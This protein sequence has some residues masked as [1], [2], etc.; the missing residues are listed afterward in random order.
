[1]RR[2]H[3]G[4]TPPLHHP[5]PPGDFKTPTACASTRPVRT[6][7]AGVSYAPI[8][9]LRTQY[10]AAAR[11]HLATKG[12]GI[13]AACEARGL[14]KTGS[15]YHGTYYWVQKYKQNGTAK[16]IQGSDKIAER[17]TA[18][19]AAVPG[20]AP[21]VVIPGSAPRVYDDIDTDEDFESYG[22]AYMK[23][24]VLMSG[25]QAKTYAKA[26]LMVQ[27]QMGWEIKKCSA[28]KS[29]K[30]F[31]L[32]V[33][34][35]PGRKP[36]MGVAAE[37][38]MVRAVHLL[39]S[40]RLPAR[41]HVVLRMATNM[42]LTV[43]LDLDLDSITGLVK[44]SWFYSFKDRHADLFDFSATKGL[45]DTR[46]DWLTSRNA[47]IHYG[48]LAEQLMQSKI[49]KRA[50]DAAAQAAAVNGE[51]IDFLSEDDKA[52]LVSF[53]ECRTTLDTY[54]DEARGKQLNPK[55]M[56]DDTLETR[57]FGNVTVV[58]GSRGDGKALP[59]MAIFPRKTM[60]KVGD[61][62]S[63]WTLDFWRQWRRVAPASPIC[64]KDG[65]PLMAK[66]MGNKSGGM[67]HD[68]GAIY[69]R[70]VIAPAMPELTKEKPGILVCDGHGSHLT[71]EFL[72]TAIALNIIVILRPPHTTSRM[73]GEDTKHGFGIFQAA[74]RAAKEDILCTRVVAGESVTV[75]DFMSAMRIA[76]DKAFTRENCRASWA[77]IGVVPF[78]RCVFWELAA[79]EKEIARCKAR[80]EKAEDVDEVLRE[81]DTSTLLTASKLEYEPP[82]NFESSSDD[83]GSSDSDHDGGPAKKRKKSFQ[84]IAFMRPVTGCEAVGVLKK[85]KK[86]K[87]EAAAAAQ[88]RADGKEEK[89]RA[90]KQMLVENGRGVL[91]KLLLFDKLQF[92]KLTIAQMNGLA[93]ALGEDE[94]PK[95]DR[96]KKLAILRPLFDKYVE[97][98]SLN[99]MEES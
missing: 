67:T 45:E 1:M 93:I 83:E 6:A 39:R 35:K 53:D 56:P 68:L 15:D 3:L 57:G 21:K 91:E 22:K 30:T 71:L 87:D 27:K 82:A 52:R 34:N 33:P 96:L 62:S 66:V 17:V 47:A 14:N 63:A 23:I 48:L 84:A 24:G 31:G 86:K 55:G 7:S 64:G 75:L 25:R 76:Y 73:Q 12:M 78:T 19:V 99:D 49:A 8:K 11:L 41:K 81:L 40:M 26:K 70:D 59:P 32:K 95:G 89:A 58:C 10:Q 13:D 97:K 38:V 29:Q 43:G 46:M 61:D 18:A 80:A 65:K 94:P 77:K 72:E 4:L 74:F 5:H 98:E 60:G 79:E 44:D 2:P 9:E 92:D 20:P 28:Y 42:V 37:E 51:I 88:T 90:A 36:K 50:T 69:L 85:A 16:I 54:Q